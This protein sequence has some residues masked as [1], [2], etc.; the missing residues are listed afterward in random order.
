MGYSAGVAGVDWSGLSHWSSQR[1]KTRCHMMA[2]WGLRIQWFSSGKMSISAG[3]P[4]RRAALKAIMP[5]EARMR[6]SYSPWVM[7]MGVFHLSMKRWGELANERC[8][9]ALVL[10]Q[11]GP[12]RSQLANH[13]SSVSRYCVSVLK[14]PAWAMKHAKRLSW[15][16]ASQY[17]ENPP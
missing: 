2:F 7:R 4:R 11:K 16:P 15:L 14:I 17:T 5:C 12:P 8:A 1:K 13:I 9:T 3:T 6:K 10:S